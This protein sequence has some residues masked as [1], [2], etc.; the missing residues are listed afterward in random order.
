MLHQCLW[1][2]G[3]RG[4]CGFF[5]SGERPE[6]S[7]LPLRREMD[8]AGLVTVWG[9]GLVDLNRHRLPAEAIVG[10]VGS[11]HGDGDGLFFLDAGETCSEF[12]FD[13]VEHR[14]WVVRAGGDGVLHG[15][16]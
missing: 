7:P 8:V 4:E 6:V 5:E 10:V 12:G 16:C 15:D 13:G 2:G 11:G 14:R 1:E 3:W 9:G